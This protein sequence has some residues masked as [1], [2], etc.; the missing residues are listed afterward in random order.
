MEIIKIEPIEYKYTKLELYALIINFSN[1]ILQL[2]I[3][4]IFRLVTAPTFGS[5]WIV[6]FVFLCLGLWI[7]TYFWSRNHHVLY[8]NRIY[9]KWESTIVD[10]RPLKTYLKKSYVANVT[11]NTDGFEAMEESK[12]GLR[13]NY[14]CSIISGMRFHSPPSNGT[15]A[16]KM[17]L[18]CTL[19]VRFY[20]GEEFAYLLLQYA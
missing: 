6:S 4:P 15:L 18:H 7:V 2:F 5:L 11:F 8:L 12:N 3:L 16:N 1:I 20:D 10:F 9:K 19:K 17:Q 13:N 14:N